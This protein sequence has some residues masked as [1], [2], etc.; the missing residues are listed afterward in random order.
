MNQEPFLMISSKL[1]KSTVALGFSCLMALVITSQAHAVAF[2]IGGPMGDAGVDLD[3]TSALYTSGRDGIVTLIAQNGAIAPGGEVFEDLGVPSISPE[4]SVVF[5]AATLGQ[6][7]HAHWDVFRFDPGAPGSQRIVRVLDGATIPETCRPAFKADPYPVAG[8]NGMV[9]FLAPEA[10]GHDAVFRYAD[11]HLSCAARIGDRTAQGHRVALLYFGSADI[12]A[13]GQLA[14]LARVE[15]VNHRGTT[16]SA[17]VTIKNDSPISEI[18][19]EGDRTPAGGRFGATFGRPAI[20]GSRFGDIVA[21][22]NR[23]ASADTAY[24]SS[25]GRLS[26]SFRTGADT[27][28]GALTYISNGRP[29]LLPDGSIVVSG[30]CHGKTAIFKAKDGELT[31]I[32][33]AGDITQFGTRLQA[34]VDPSVTASG[35][36][37][38]GGHDESGIERLFVFESSEATEI[39]IESIADVSADGRWMPPFFPGSLAVNQR[40]DLVALGAA[41]SPDPGVARTISFD[42]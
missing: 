21:F 30:A 14:F 13:D 39:P 18:A 22:T 42:R 26:R 28:L 11:G 20:V 37:F 31:A 33:Q 27:A 5:G 23:N 8:A 7:G 41:S 1:A 12:A 36:V 17:V 3:T 10:S 9:A 38:L 16:E 34:F 6:D 4:G 15:D 19:R 25:A 40:G 2:N 35:L 29:G 24:V 32:R